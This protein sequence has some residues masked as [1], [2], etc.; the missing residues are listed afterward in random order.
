ME[1]V[2]WRRNVPRP[3]CPARDRPLGSRGDPSGSCFARKR[4]PRTVGCLES[5]V[6]GSTGRNRTREDRDRGR[7]G[8]AIPAVAGIL[9]ARP[10]RHR[11][12]RRSS[13]ARD[14]HLPRSPAFGG[15]SAIPTALATRSRRS[16]DFLRIN[17]KRESR[18]FETTAM[19]FRI[20]FV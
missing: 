5:R 12:R 6:S 13:R 3:R 2:R 7:P 16:T 9:K 1:F 17:E 19:K 14:R 11:P 10:P 8:P 4:G 20:L 18:E 15:P